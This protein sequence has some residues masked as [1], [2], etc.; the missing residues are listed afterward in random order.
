MHIYVR[1]SLVY[2]LKKLVYLLHKN[3]Y[4]EKNLIPFLF[5]YKN[6]TSKIQV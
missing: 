6:A 4:R 1:I 2:N 5:I 3:H